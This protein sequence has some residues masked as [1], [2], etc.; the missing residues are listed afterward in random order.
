VTRNSVFV[1]RGNET[2]IFYPS[3]LSTDR[4]GNTRR[5]AADEGFP[6]QVSVAEDRSSVAE[7]PGTIE[8]R[9]L[10]LVLR[11]LP[12][13]T[14]EATTWDRIVFR[15]QEWD[16]ATPPWRSGWNRRLKHWEIT[17]RSRNKSTEGV[18]DG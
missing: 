13:D 2:A 15:G 11:R 10:K 14:G 3:T 1:D 6:V 16:M 17:L 7:L 18:G 5:H 12:T 4:R 8:N 9:I